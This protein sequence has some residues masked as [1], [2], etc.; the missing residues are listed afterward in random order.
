MSTNSSIPSGNDAQR[1]ALMR[2]LAAAEQIVSSSPVLPTS[3]DVA[4]DFDGGYT[5]RFNFHRDPAAVFTFAEYMGA[6]TEARLHRPTVEADI[7]TSAAGIR[8]GVEF[9]AW[10]LDTAESL[11]AGLRPVADGV[12]AVAA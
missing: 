2:A 10:S 1:S 7:Y 8:D 3:T 12:S 5:L 11:A 9:T 6:R 4:Y